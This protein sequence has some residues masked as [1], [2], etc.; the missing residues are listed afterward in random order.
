MV[1]WFDKRMCW[2]D[3]G[4]RWLM[5]GCV[6]SWRVALFLVLIKLCK[7]DGQNYM[8]DMIFLKYVSVDKIYKSSKIFT[9][10]YIK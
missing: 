3:K 7:K 9:T 10:I 8:V 1:H 2:F 4:T 6:G 5:K